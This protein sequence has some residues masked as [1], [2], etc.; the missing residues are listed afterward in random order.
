MV[1]F[2]RA[3]C[4]LTVVS[5]IEGESD[6]AKWAEANDYRTAW[7]MALITIGGVMQ[8]IALY[9]PPPKAPH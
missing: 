2:A 7:G 9:I 6:Y 1:K 8:V 5:R 4:L 3:I